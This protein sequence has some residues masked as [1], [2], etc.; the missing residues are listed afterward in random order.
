MRN[1]TGRARTSLVMMVTG[2]LILATAAAAFADGLNGDADND[3]LSS[4]HPTV[5]ATTQDVGTTVTYPFAVTVGNTSPASNDVFRAGTNDFVTVAI[6]RDGTWVDSPAGTPTQ[7]TLT[8]YLTQARG[9]VTITVPRD[10]CDVTNT[11][12][13]G[14]RATASNGQAM[15]PRSLSLSFRITGTG[16]CGPWTVTETASLTTSTTARA[17]PTQIRP[18]PTVTAS[19][20][21]AT[22]TRSRPACATPR[23]EPG[24]RP[25]GIALRVAGSFSDGDGTVTR[26]T[27]KN[28]VATVDRSCDG[29]WSWSLTP[30]DDGGG[31]VD[32]QAD[33]G[34]HTATDA[35]AW[36]AVNV[37]PTADITNDGPIDEGGSATVSLTNPF[38]PSSEDT[39]A[40]FRYAFSCT[41]DG[42]LPPTRTRARATRRRAP[43]T[44]TVPTRSPA[45]SS[46]RTTATP[47]IRPRCGAQRRADRH[48]C[49]CFGR[50]R[51]RLPAGQRGRLELLL[52]RPGGLERHLQLRR[53]LGRRL[54]ARR[55]RPGRT[56]RSPASATRTGRA[57]SQIS[58][59]VSDEDGGASTPSTRRG[60]PSV[61]DEW[62]P[63]AD[64]ADG[65][66]QLQARQHDPGEASPQRLHGRPGDGLDL[67]V[68]LAM[69]GSAVAEAASNGDTG[70]RYTGGQYHFDLSTKRSQFAGGQDLTAGTYHLWVTGP[71]AETDAVVD[72]R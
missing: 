45:A 7:L 71:I 66:N 35:F 70:M 46:T 43:S 16:T 55:P 68:H 6:T 51:R 17:S 49:H 30:A 44:T 63:A 53:R 72:L 38:D 14:L 61:R 15:R 28:G 52:E 3:A 34:A 50:L 1:G 33:D 32:V 57:R 25:R 62:A 37:A 69:G 12:T 5:L 13:V 41:N 48:G 58:I 54:G 31:S 42:S 22:A 60:A 59:V 65:P 24:D 27:K 10:A 36:S 20:T 26:A 9:T 11:T 21:S 40:G 67:H 23:P 29:T 64:Q 8:H 18:T 4:P 39:T 19:A 2:F 56:L 47:T